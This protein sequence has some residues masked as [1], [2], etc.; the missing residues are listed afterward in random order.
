[1]LSGLLKCGRCGGG[2]TTSRGDRYYC[3]ARREKG[4]CD[5]SRGISASELEE[6]VLNGLKDI[7]LGSE[8]LLDEFVAEFKRE[9]SRLRKER[10]DTGRQLERDLERVERGIQR[11]LDFIAGGDGEPGLVRDQLR[12]LEAQKSEIDTRLMVQQADP[13]VTILPNLPDL[14][15]RKVARLRSLLEDE[16]ERPCAVELI[17]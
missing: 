6:R 2:M 8:A 12:R 1:M 14:Y 4:T 11:C 13:Q 9:V 10:Y 3:S 5:A 7:L 16:A 15:R 17:R